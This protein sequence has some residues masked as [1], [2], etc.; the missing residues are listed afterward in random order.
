MTL[1]L[2]VVGS[3]DC[4]AKGVC[5]NINTRKEG[6]ASP[7]I[8]N[9]FYNLSE[10]TE[11]SNSDHRTRRP[12]GTCSTLWAVGKGKRPGQKQ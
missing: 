2:Q 1:H 10:H 6:L 5:C 7:S 12:R 4:R 9:L 11:T 8:Q 3:L